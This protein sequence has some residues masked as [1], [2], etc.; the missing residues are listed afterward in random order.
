METS[1]VA[2]PAARR[3]SVLARR[4]RSRRRP[5]R[6]E[7]HSAPRMRR[8]TF[9]SARRRRF[10]TS[11]VVIS[12][13]VMLR[14]FGRSHRTGHGLEWASAGGVSIGQ[15]LWQSRRGPSAGAHVA[16][17]LVG[18]RIDDVERHATKPAQ[19]QGSRKGITCANR[20]HNDGRNRR[21]VGPFARLKQ[22][23]ARRTACQS[24]QLETERLREGLYLVPNGT[25]SGQTTAPGSVA[26]RRSA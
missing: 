25:A 9:D 13:V 2:R 11:D 3:K 5:A 19:D 6:V 22:Q 21:A 17:D 1:A 12:V 16:R 20:I 26:R 23:A 24:N 4:G 14:V 10:L 15:V 8:L 7:A 18:E